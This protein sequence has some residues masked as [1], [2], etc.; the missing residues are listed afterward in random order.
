MSSPLANITVNEVMS[1]VP[2]SIS[3]EVTVSQAY[4]LMRHKHLGGLPVIENGALVGVITRTDI[5][6][7]DIER[8]QKTKVNEIMSK[9][10]IT[11]YQEEKVSA[12]LERMTN[13]HVRR[14][15]VISTTGSLVGWLSL[16]DI[17]KAAQILR[18]R[19]ISKC[20]ICGATLPLTISR[21]VT[22]QHCDN[23]SNV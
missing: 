15:P 3:P 5:K 6:K 8:T 7:V 4:G 2:Y 19:K 22:C 14:A 11:V 21:T 18:N 12:A 16:S 9:Q 10:P 23:I 1:L 20:P 17:E 13:L